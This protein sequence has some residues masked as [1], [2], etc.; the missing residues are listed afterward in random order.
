[1]SAQPRIRARLAASAGAFGAVLRN[2]AL[3]RVE[4]AFLGFN[5]TEWGIWVAIL[6]FAYGRGGAGEV[7]LVA[8]LQL[9]PAA[10]VAPLAASFGDRYPRE[11]ALL[12]AYLLQAAV[13]AAMA[14]S[15]LG[16]AP[17]AIVYLLAAVANSTITLTRP[18][19]A[20]ILPSLSRTPAEL[21]AANVAAGSIETIAILVGPAVAGL[22]LQ[23]L[24]PGPVF[25]AAAV[26][27]LAGAGLVAGLPRTIA[28]A[29]AARSTT[30]GSTLTEAV[31]GFTMLAR[32]EKPRSVVV[33][34]G[35]AS[36]LWGT[37]DVLL[38]VLALDELSMGKSGVGFLNAAIGAGGIV[39]A[40]LTALLIGRSRLAGPFG[41]GLVLWGGALAAIGLLPLPVVALLLLGLAGMGRVVMDVAGRT[42]LQRVS[43]DA[44]LS[45]VFGV[46]EG[47][48]NGSLAL[49]SLVA[50]ALLAVAGTRGAFIAAGL[51][52]IT[53]TALSWRRLLR[54]DAAGTV[55]PR[56]LAALMGVPFFAPLP[57]PALERLAAALIPVSARAG[58]QIIVQGHAG[59]RFY[60]ISSGTVEV[61]IDGVRVRSMSAGESFGEIAL[62]RDVP[63]IASVIAVTEVELLA[64][65][66]H[67]FVETV[68]GQPVAAE[69]AEAVI[70]AHL[71][72]ASDEGSQTDMG[73]LG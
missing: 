73:R 66:R 9:A 28:P 7:A 26:I 14:A 24:G 11:R 10:V 19:Q 43:P 53:F 5:L 47:I 58:T 69:A 2:P 49:G 42:L 36:V 56:E 68:T 16:H 25:A 50:P 32:E 72:H 4:L 54:A 21:T 55:H 46:L 18:V 33:L 8:V 57:G 71:E 40:L 34:L 3:R 13:T 15:L 20:A 64:L 31:A 67:H 59:D 51:A 48:D 39:G 62:L 63:R 29:G 6:V 27:S 60:I 41:A 65:D 12:A 38:V 70:H 30:R 17:V 22:V 52:L 61:S 35:S 37:I 44:L 23:A 45:R 1:M